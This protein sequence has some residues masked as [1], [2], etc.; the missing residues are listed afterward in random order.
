MI[1][2]LDSE[3]VQR[4][5]RRPG[6]FRQDLQLAQYQTQLFPGLPDRTSQSKHVYVVTKP[7]IPF[8]VSRCHWSVYS[9]GYFYHLSARLPKNLTGQSAFS[10]LKNKAPRAQI[11]LKIE[12][13]ST[14]NSADYVKAA[15]EAST[16]PFVA[17]EM[18]EFPHNPSP[19]RNTLLVWA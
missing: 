18:L 11:V 10:G 16:K 3:I 9:Q 4:I 15:T 13:L 1:K 2:V 17:Y 6:F 5:G 14:T 8:E 12:D 19:F 7:R